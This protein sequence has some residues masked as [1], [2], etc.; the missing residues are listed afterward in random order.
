MTVAERR[1]RSPGA[2][3]TLSESTANGWALPSSWYSWP[4]AVSIAGGG[5]LEWSTAPVR[6]IR[7]TGLLLDYQLRAWSVGMVP[8]NKRA[9]HLADEMGILAAMSFFAT[10]TFPLLYEG[11]G[12]RASLRQLADLHN[13]PCAQCWHPAQSACSSLS[14]S[15]CSRSR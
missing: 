3:A 7:P 14:A 2:D 15:V 6:M 13:S 5:F 4:F 12:V 11:I 8:E 9:K 10:V 1:Y